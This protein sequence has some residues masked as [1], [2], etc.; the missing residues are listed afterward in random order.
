MVTSRSEG[1]GFLVPGLPTAIR[2]RPRRPR[3]L[4]TPSRHT[5]RP[6]PIKFNGGC[7]KVWRPLVRGFLHPGAAARES[8][9]SGEDLLPAGLLGDGGS[10]KAS[11]RIWGSIARPPLAHPRLN[12]LWFAG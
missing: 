1:S 12:S 2:E 6:F 9:R 11:G 5:G 10:F 3:S 8:H 4:P 7:F